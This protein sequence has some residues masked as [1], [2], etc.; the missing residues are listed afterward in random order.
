MKL[1]SILKAAFNANDSQIKDDFKLSDFAEW[2]SMQHML[3]I[4]KLEAE[5]NVDLNGDEIASIKTI[6]DIK[7]TLSA[8]GKLD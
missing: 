5:Y 2:D 3:F 6:G 8:K 4:T 7:K 1:V